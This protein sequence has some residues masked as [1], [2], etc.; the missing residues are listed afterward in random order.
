M[1]LCDFTQGTSPTP[2]PPPPPPKKTKKTTTVHIR[3][4]HYHFLSRSTREA[5]LLKKNSR[6]YGKLYGRS[7]QSSQITPA[8]LQQ[9]LSLTAPLPTQAPPP[10]PITALPS[11]PSPPSAMPIPKP[12]STP[13]KPPPTT[14]PN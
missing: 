6:K 13:I 4:P 10:P 14:P 8:S 12:L 1:A 9:S 2:A 11:S 3:Y 7:S 5:I